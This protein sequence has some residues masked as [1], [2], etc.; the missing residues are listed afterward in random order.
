MSMACWFQWQHIKPISHTPKHCA[1][2]ANNSSMCYLLPFSLGNRSTDE[3]DLYG[4]F[5]KTMT[6]WSYWKQLP[7][8]HSINTIIQH[9]CN[10]LAAK[11]TKKSTGFPMLPMPISSSIYSIDSV[12]FTSLFIYAKYSF[13]R[14]SSI[15]QNWKHQK[16]RLSIK[17]HFSAAGSRAKLTELMIPSA[18]RIIEFLSNFANIFSFSSFGYVASVFFFSIF[19]RKLNVVASNADICPLNIPWIT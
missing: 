6:S 10:G 16:Q 7:W 9:P 1:A 15:D 12:A 3:A 18:L 14:Y 2:H 11:Q 5:G 8:L 13:E 17:F 4:I 19:Q